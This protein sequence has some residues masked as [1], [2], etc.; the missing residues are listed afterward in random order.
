MRIYESLASLCNASPQ[1]IYIRTIFNR[2]KTW[3]S[4]IETGLVFPAS[5]HSQLNSG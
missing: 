1:W 3:A 4:E 2:R 5:D